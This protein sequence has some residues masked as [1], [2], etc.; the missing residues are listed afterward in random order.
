MFYLLF[1]FFQHP[2]DSH[3]L[4]LDVKILLLISE[5]LDFWN[6]WIDAIH[7]LSC[8]AFIKLVIR[9]HT[10]GNDLSPRTTDL[11]DILFFI[12]QIISLHAFKTHHGMI[13]ETHSC[14]KL[15]KCLELC[16]LIHY[17]FVVSNVHMGIAEILQNQFYIFIIVSVINGDVKRRVFLA[18][19]ISFYV[20]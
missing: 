2:I 1:I 8:E 15:N 20:V 14:R 18:G 3:S 11:N 16:N 9:K 5:F 6:V 13:L 12:V 19:R 7:C 17:V 4:D 10:V